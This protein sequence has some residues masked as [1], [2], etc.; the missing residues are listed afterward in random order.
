MIKIKRF[1]KIPHKKNNLIN[2]IKQVRNKI[3]INKI[4]NNK[5]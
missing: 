2:Y 3:K 4:I 1:K 5:N